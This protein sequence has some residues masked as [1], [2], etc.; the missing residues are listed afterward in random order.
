MSETLQPAGGNN[1]PLGNNQYAQ[2]EVNFDNIQ[3]DK[4]LAP[5]GTSR[6]AGLRR[7]RKD[8]PEWMR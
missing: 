8:R 1:N 5:T 3:D 6:A 4:V 2:K 7:L